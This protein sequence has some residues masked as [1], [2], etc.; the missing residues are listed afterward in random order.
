MAS[1]PINPTTQF[2]ILFSLCILISC[3]KEKAVAVDFIQYQLPTELNLR[4]IKVISPDT[5]WVAAGTQFDKGALLKTE[6]AAD[7]WQLKLDAG[8]EIRSFTFRNDR[9]YLTP[10]GNTIQSSADEAQNWT[11]LI[12]PGWEYFTACDFWDDS[13]GIVVGGENFG[14]GIV[15]RVKLSPSPTLIKVDTIQHELTDIHIINDSTCIAVGYGVILRSTDMGLNWI[16]DKARG[17]FF[18]DIHFIDAQNGY[19]VGEYGSI[20]K[21][22]DAGLSWTKIK[23]GTTVFN[24]KHRFKKVFFEDLNNGVI[25]GDQGLC[26]VTKNAGESWIPVDNLPA[27][28]LSALAIYSQKVYVGGAAGQLLTFEWP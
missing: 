23:S 28:N 2:L 14:K 27:I 18:Q 19:V 13:L 10:I 8:S 16:P 20:Y 15:Y 17:D 7:N 12:T 21:T 1:K 25:V 4:D 26:W 24:A 6:D 5:I 9:I 22:T 3:K 11:T